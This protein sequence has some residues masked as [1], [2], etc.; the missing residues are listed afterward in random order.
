[1]VNFLIKYR[2]EFD[3]KKKVFLKHLP[4]LGGFNLWLRKFSPP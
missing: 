3:R 4:I 2:E 1:M